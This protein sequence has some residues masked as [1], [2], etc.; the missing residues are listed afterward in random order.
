LK[1]F[2]TSLD[3]WFKRKGIR[4]WLTE[5]GYETKEDGERKGVSRAQQ[6]AYTT[7]VLR[8]ARNDPRID[9]FI[10]FVFRDNPSSLWQSG[11]MSR[12]GRVK[13]ALARF[14]SMAA[15]VDARNAMVRVKGGTRN[16]V[17]TI[18]LRDYGHGTAAGETV[19]FK[20][21]VSQRGRLVTNGQTNAPFGIDAAS[22]IRLNGF[23]PLKGRTY[24]VNVEA[25]VFSGGG[26]IVRRALTVIG[27]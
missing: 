10:W 3:K 25:D 19:A 5:Y 2:E 1:R 11:M 27:I 4:L 13:P 7:Q 21:R 15:A 12:A 6:A 18:P 26:V 23:R 24:V 20:F 8:I 9:M 17:V 14:R 22:R 16:P